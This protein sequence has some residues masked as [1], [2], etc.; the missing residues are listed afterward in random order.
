MIK[1]T[2]NWNMAC[3]PWKQIFLL[4]LEVCFAIQ[5]C[6][7][8]VA[9]AI[10]LTWGQHHHVTWELLVILH[11]E[12]IPNLWP[13]WQTLPSALQYCAY[14]KLQS[15]PS[16]D[17][18]PRINE[19]KQWQLPRWQTASRTLTSLDGTPSTL[20]PLTTWVGRLLTSLSLLC[21]SQS[22]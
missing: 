1:R 8:D 7:G 6:S 18:T 17:S 11:Q 21:L 22:S 15:E 10:W 12:Y 2:I 16:Y 5:V 14:S 19:K 9:G 3:N 20:L 4:N 13:K